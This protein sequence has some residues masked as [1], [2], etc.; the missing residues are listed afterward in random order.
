MAVDRR[1]DPLAG[2]GQDPIVGPQEAVS[3]AV[4]C[5]G[6]ATSCREGLARGIDD[7]V[8]AMPCKDFTREALDRDTLPA[9]LR[10]KK[11]GESGVH[12]RCLSVD[13]NDPEEWE[14][15]SGL[16]VA[17]AVVLGPPR[18]G[19]TGRLQIGLPAAQG[20]AAKAYLLS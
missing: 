6:A 10:R 17:C 9:K 14:S 13:A 20:K 5:G 1:L 18:Q 16:G 11:A 4:D 15:S 7:A 19:R 12:F 2:L 8:A 3:L